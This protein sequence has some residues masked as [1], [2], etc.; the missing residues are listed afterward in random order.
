MFRISLEGFGA[1]PQGSEMA[2]NFTHF[3]LDISPAHPEAGT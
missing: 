2:I 3:D 1:G